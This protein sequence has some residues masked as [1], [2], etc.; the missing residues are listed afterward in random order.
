[1]TANAFRPDDGVRATILIDGK[2]REFHLYLPPG[3]HDPIGWFDMDDF[4][5]GILC[6]C[7]ESFFS[8]IGALAGTIHNEHRARETA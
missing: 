2:P 1:M 3:P 6:R 7:G 5:R 4:G 8:D